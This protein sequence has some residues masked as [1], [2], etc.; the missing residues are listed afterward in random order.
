MRFQEF[1]KSANLKQQTILLTMTTRLLIEAEEAGEASE[2][3]EEAKRI[4]D[5]RK[6]I[7]EEEENGT[8][9]RYSNIRDQKIVI[10]SD[11]KG[12]QRY[13]NEKFR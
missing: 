13:L 2:N 6:K 7:A 3:I 4:A 1:Q 11:E 5:A 8:K 12:K 10:F 9:K